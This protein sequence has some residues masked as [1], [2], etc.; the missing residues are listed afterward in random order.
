MT[1]SQICR[2]GEI[3]GYSAASMRV[4]ITRL[5]RQGKV[6]RPARGEYALNSADHRLQLTVSDWR[7]RM[8]A[9]IP[10][11]GLWIGVQD[12]GVSR[13]DRAHARAHDLALD[14]GG[15]RRWRP[16]LCI[17]PNNLAGGVAALR[18]ELHSLGMMPQAEVFSIGSLSQEQEHAVVQLWDT[19]HLLRDYTRKLALLSDSLARLD[20]ALAL[21]EVRPTTLQPAQADQ[22]QA[23][24]RDCETAAAREC[25]LLGRA[26]IADLLRDPR[27]PEPLA[28][29]APRQAVT[30]A[31][32]QYQSSAKRLWRLLLAR[33]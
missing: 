7:A 20:A 15:F 30:E 27:L 4:A 17:R 19:E 26:L 32:A 10:W 31:L 21:A 29:T 6:T 9:V 11:S 18:S 24:D 14:L 25:L 28:T 3:M 22:E 2:G 12:G 16:G 33:Q 13:T 1:V 5:A 23:P 8:D